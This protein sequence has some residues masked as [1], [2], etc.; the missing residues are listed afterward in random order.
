MIYF[1]VITCG[2]PKSEVGS[3]VTGGSLVVNSEIR[4]H[5]EE[6]R[7]MSGAAVRRC[8]HDGT[9][10]GNAPTCDCK[11]KVILLHST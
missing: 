11:Y 1:L 7:K 10:S 2:E 4:Y 3:Y 5:C 8:Q 6:G 9:W